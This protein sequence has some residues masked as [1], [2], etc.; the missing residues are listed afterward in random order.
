MQAP[1]PTTEAC[2][3]RVALL[4]KE[5]TLATRQACS[6]SAIFDP[7]PPSSFP[8]TFSPQEPGAWLTPRYLSRTSRVSQGGAG[9]GRTGGDNALRA[10]EREWA[11]RSPYRNQ[12]V[13]PLCRSAAPHS[14]A[15]PDPHTPHTYTY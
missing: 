1:V 2:Q 11:K 8:C 15:P 5:E 13:G 12:A 7:S 4:A 14:L 3:G 6:P 10:L 9:R